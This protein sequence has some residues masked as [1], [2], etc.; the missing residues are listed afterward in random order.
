MRL[1]LKEIDDWRVARLSAA[2]ADSLAASEAVQLRVESVEVVYER[3]F[4][5]LGWVDVMR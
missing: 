1:D 3:G 5:I 2:Q 4:V